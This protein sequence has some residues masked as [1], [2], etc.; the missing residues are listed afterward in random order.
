[1]V[2]VTA[3]IAIA[4]LSLVLGWLA[5]LLIDPWDRDA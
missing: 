1:M 4:G 2:W 3:L 5:R